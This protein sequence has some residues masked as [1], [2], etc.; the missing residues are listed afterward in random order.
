MK[1][2]VSWPDS[3]KV[4]EWYFKTSSSDTDKRSRVSA[5]VI[6]DIAAAQPQIVQEINDVKTSKK[7][8]FK[9]KKRDWYL[10]VQSDLS[11]SE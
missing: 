3:I 4:S 10:N 6:Y 8:C 2:R 7:E 9:R 1:N 5:D 11:L